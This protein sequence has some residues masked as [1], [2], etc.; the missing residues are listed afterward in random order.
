MS[1]LPSEDRLTAIL[2]P[3]AA[4]AGLVIDGVSI[5][6]A[7]R[8]RL[9]RVDV[10]L[11]EDVLG[12][13]DLDS[14]AAASRAISAALDASPETTDVIGTGPY[15]LEVGTAGIGRPLR[16]RRHWMRARTR[17]VTVS[18]TGGGSVTGRLQQVDDEGIH[19]AVTGATQSLPWPEVGAGEVQ[20]EFR[21]EETDKPSDEGRR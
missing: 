2:T 16:Q 7:G 19:L 17:L 6:T 5:A 1:T 18:T 13:V 21:R 10:D 12:S 3:A 9:V 20:V 8:R 4:T 11:P 14:V 15:A